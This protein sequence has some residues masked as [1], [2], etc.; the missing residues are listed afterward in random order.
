MTKQELLQEGICL[1]QSIH[2]KY[3]ESLGMHLLQ[4]YHYDDEQRYKNWLEMAQGYV[5]E[6]KIY[7]EQY[8]EFKRAKEEM[9]LEGHKSILAII[10]SLNS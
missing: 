9:S 8:E 7:P 3:D 5:Y 6:N 10:N 1:T 4:G 2:A